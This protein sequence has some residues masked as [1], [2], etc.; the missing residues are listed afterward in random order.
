MKYESKSI[1][2]NTVIDI[3]PN[4]IDIEAKNKRIH[5]DF[6]DYLGTHV[7]KN[8]YN[9]IYTG[10]TRY[11][12]FRDE[13]AKL[14]KRRMIN[15]SSREKED[16]IKIA[17]DIDKTM[18][19]RSAKSDE[20]MNY[21]DVPRTFEV[22]KETIKSNS[23][24]YILL[25]TVL[26]MVLITIALIVSFFVKDAV[27]LTIRVFCI[28]GYIVDALLFI[29]EMRY[30]VKGLKNI[31]E[32]II[33]DLYAVKIDDDSFARESI[34]FL[35]ITP[36]TYRKWER[37]LTIRDKDGDHIFSFGSSKNDLKKDNPKTMPDYDQLYRTL[38]LW[39]HLN[40]VTFYS[41]LG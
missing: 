34:E 27:G 14:G 38:R 30:T 1:L 6:A 18:F 40:N 13:T 2:G 19:D 7:T 39:C 33:T 21:F 17:A 28:A 29:P 23:I 26:P 20:I 9:G 11:I 3:N 36:S 32:R 10:M 12:S 25:M 24:K 4:G 22:P 5:Y 41:D 8:Y 15:F 31:P 37:R 35:K 16:F